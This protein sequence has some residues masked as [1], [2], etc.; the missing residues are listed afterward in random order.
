MFSELL[1]RLRSQKGVTQPQLAEAIGVS[2][3]NVGDWETGKS[4]PGYQAIVALARYFDVS[5]DYLLE[6]NQTPDSNTKVSTPKEEEALLSVYR[7]LDMRDKD[8]LF[9]IA[10]LKEENNK[11]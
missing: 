5:A 6:L 1:K 3:G 10:K 2:K 8:E 7:K 9:K 4:K 11:Q